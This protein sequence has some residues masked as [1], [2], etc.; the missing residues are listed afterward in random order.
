MFVSW[1]SPQDDPNDPLTWSPRRKLLALSCMIAYMMAV[2]VSTAAMYSVFGDIQ[3]NST[4][5]LNNL[6][7]G[8]GYM[9]SLA[10]VEAR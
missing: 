9:V 10:A 5:T 6:N 2:G 3:A 1:V 8:T 7:Q 4:L